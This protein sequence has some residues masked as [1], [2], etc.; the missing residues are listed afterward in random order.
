[1]PIRC[2]ELIAFGLAKR[3]WASPSRMITPSATRGASSNS[4]SSRGNGKLPS[5]IIRASRSNT[6]KYWRS[7]EPARRPKV[8][9]VSRVTSPIRLPSYRTGMHLI[10]ARSVEPSALVSPSTISPSRHARLTSGRSTSPTTVPTMSSVYRVWS[11]V[12]RTWPSTTKRWP[13]S[14]SMAARNKRSAKQRSASTC[15]DAMSRRVCA[16]ASPPRAVCVRASSNP[17]VLPFDGTGEVRDAGCSTSEEG[18][19]DAGQSG[20]VVDVDLEVRHVRHDLGHASELGLELRL[21]RRHDG[22][23]LERLADGPE[24]PSRTRGVG[25]LG[26]A[27]EGELLRDRSRLRREDVGGAGAVGREQVLG[28]RL[29]QD[30]RDEMEVALGEL[31]AEELRLSEGCPLERRHDPERRAPVVQQPL[32]GLG[33]AREP[34][35]HRLEAEEELGDI[36]QELAAEDAIG[37]LVEGPAGDI[38]D[39]RTAASAHPVRHGEP[40]EETTTEEVGH[41]ARRL[42]ELDRVPGR[43]GVDDDE[44]VPTGGVDVEQPLHRDVVVAL[45][46]SPRDV[47]V[48]AVLEDPVG[49]LLVGCVAEHELVPRSLGVEHGGVQLAARFEPGCLERL[50]RDRLLD[51][52]EVLEAQRVREPARRVDREHEHLPAQ[53]SSGRDTGGGG[54]RGLADAARPTEHDDLLRGEQRLDAGGPGLGARHSPSSWARESATIF[55]T[56]NPWSR[57]KR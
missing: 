6:S 4:T 10:R 25:E 47:R 42:E 1:M 56:R 16:S 18:V 23:V 40:P 57:T 37:E 15:H 35:V 51:V 53:A 3:I 31:L 21:A 14:P 20:H 41:A 33:A 13:S 39:A 7:S 17:S 5:A 27:G 36:L 24:H 52:P 45:H 30:E 46:E 55:V 28:Q 2:S 19:P 9:G 54:H 32:D 49:G 26:D 8:R 43:R 11:V 22:E 12:G 44:V 48:Q 50:D 34:V 29:V 38:E